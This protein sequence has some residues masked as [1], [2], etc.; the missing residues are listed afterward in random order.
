MSSYYSLKPLMWNVLNYI[1]NIDCPAILIQS[2]HSLSALHRSLRLLESFAAEMLNVLSAWCSLRSPWRD[3]SDVWALRPL[4]EATQVF[5]TQ[6]DSCQV[7]GLIFTGWSPGAAT[8]WKVSF[9][10]LFQ[11]DRKYAKMGRDPNA[12]SV[13][14]WQ[15]SL[16]DLLWLIVTWCNH[17]ILRG[18]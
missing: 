8:V 5:Y 12:L 18:I 2:G 17:N 1:I 3:A 9:S 6:S 13:F 16:K 15:I 10:T 11:F 7:L 4:Q 14:S